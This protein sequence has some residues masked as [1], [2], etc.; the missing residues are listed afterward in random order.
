MFK[1]F[2]KHPVLNNRRFIFELDVGLLEEELVELLFAQ[3]ANA[4]QLIAI[5]ER[6]IFFIFISKSLLKFLALN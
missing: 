5:I 6:S 2:L 1:H 4:I 3:P